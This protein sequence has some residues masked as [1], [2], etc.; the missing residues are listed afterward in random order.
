MQ[1]LQ[2]ALEANSLEHKL[3][4]LIKASL[5]SNEE[6]LPT[7]TGNDTEQLVQGKYIDADKH[8]ITN[9]RV[10]KFHHY[11]CKLNYNTR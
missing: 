6:E 8:N 4:M 3:E 10:E 1:T 11:I 5:D 7:Q 9:L 2:E